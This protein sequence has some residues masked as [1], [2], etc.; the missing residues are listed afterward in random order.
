MPISL[1][2]GDNPGLPRRRKARMDGQIDIHCYDCGKY[3]MTLPSYQGYST[4]L[5][6][7]CQ[8]NRNT[9]D[10]ALEESGQKK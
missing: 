4:A 8:G 7:E 5:C 1:Y 2:D 9:L 3:I 6:T 10:K